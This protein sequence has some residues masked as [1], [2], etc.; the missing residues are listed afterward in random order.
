MTYLFIAG[1]LAFKNILTLSKKFLESSD[2][3]KGL[4]SLIKLDKVIHH[5]N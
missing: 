3:N 2:K 5:R 4:K 1:I